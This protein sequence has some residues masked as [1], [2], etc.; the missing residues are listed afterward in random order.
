[1]DVTPYHFPGDSITCHAEAAVVGGRFVDVT[2][3]RVDGNYQ[4][5]H[6]TAAAKAIGV[7][8][9]D[10]A[11]GE[12]VMVF[13]GPGTI[14]DVQ[15]GAALTAGDRIQVGANGTAAVLAAGVEVGVAMDDIANGAHGPIRLTR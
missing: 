15:A 3:P 9:R 2:G 13:G 14:I 6:A 11:I 10:K 12:K 5:S 1:M 4:V 8:S 7:A